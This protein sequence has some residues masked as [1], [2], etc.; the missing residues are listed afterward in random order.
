M[1]RKQHE[2]RSFKCLNRSRSSRAVIPDSHHHTAAA[3]R[4][5][6]TPT[7]GFPTTTLYVVVVVF[8]VVFAAVSASTNRH[9]L[10]RLV[11]RLAI[12]LPN[13]PPPPTREN[14]QQQDSQPSG[15]L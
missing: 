1:G 2:M 8:A 3:D 14:G 15:N 11:A 4:H 12:Y 7:V 13:H 6:P 5:Q 9:Q 10:I